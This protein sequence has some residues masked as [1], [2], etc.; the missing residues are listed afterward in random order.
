MYFIKSLTNL[1]TSVTAAEIQEYVQ[2]VALRQI[3]ESK[4][5]KQLSDKFAEM[6]KQNFTVSDLVMNNVTYVDFRKLGR[7][8]LEVFSDKKFF[9]LG[10]FAKIWGARIWV[11]SKTKYQL[12]NQEIKFYKKVDEALTEDFPEIVEALFEIDVGPKILLSDVKE[13]LRK[14]DLSRVRIFESDGEITTYGERIEILSRLV[15]KDN[16]EKILEHIRLS[17][18]SR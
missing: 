13:G 11:L 17:E 16:A 3:A 6:E 8:K 15:G 7:D 1:T 10:L 4:F 14:G 9:E 18:N 2:K 12:E 5:L